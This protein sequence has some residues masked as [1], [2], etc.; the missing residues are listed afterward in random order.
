MLLMLLRVRRYGLIFLLI[1]P[2]ARDTNFLGDDNDRKAFFMGSCQD[3]WAPKS[4]MKGT[5]KMDICTFLVRDS[6]T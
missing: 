5:R 4:T 6:S 1:Y 3:C 2:A